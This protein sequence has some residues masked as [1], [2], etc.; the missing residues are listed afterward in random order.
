[1][2]TPANESRPAFSPDGRWIAYQ[3]NDGGTTELFVRPSDTAGGAGGR[4]QISQA[5]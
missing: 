1:M 3:S 4:W 2:R 5:A